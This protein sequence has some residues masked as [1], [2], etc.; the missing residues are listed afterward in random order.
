MLL[1]TTCAASA[2]TFTYTDGTI[3]GTEMTFVTPAIGSG[4]AGQIHLTVPGIGTVDAWC[5]DLLDTFI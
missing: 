1:A 2:V 5:V 3:T 4:I